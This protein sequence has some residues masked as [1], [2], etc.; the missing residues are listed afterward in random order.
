MNT[1]SNFEPLEREHISASLAGTRPFYWSIRRELWENR[2]IYIAPFIITVVV[3]IGSVL[4][5][6]TLPLRMHSLATSDP[7]RLQAM[8]AKPLHFAPAPIMMTTFIVAMFYCLDALYGERRDRSI[9]FWKSLPVSDRTTVMAKASIPLL[10]LPLIAFLLSVAT[11]LAML[12]V[13]TPLLAGSAVSTI[14]LWGR[15]VAGL[16]VMFYGLAVHALWFAPIYG[17]FLLVS[18][19]AKR[20]PLIWAFLPL[21][22]AL[23]VEHTA[24]GTKYFGYMLQ[25]RLMGAMKEAFVMRRN[26]A[27]HIEQINQLR[28]GNFLITPGL[29]VGLAFAALCLIL[30]VRLRRNRE[31]I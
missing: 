9:L 14:T 29:W 25:Y 20:T 21:I 2:S 22:A 23:A 19:W 6:L 10:V 18:G 26:S 3:F 7:A 16:P 1:P 30:A 4:T 13:S 31:S 27:G 5:L 8:A 15:F 11:Q 24:F 17:W 12:I 28:L